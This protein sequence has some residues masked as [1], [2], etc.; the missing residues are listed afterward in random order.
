MLNVC[1]ECYGFGRVP[2]VYDGMVPCSCAKPDGPL[3]DDQAALKTA[4][5]WSKVDAKTTATVSLRN[6][7]EAAFRWRAL[8]DEH[9]DVCVISY[10]LMEH[11]AATFKKALERLGS[12]E[13]FTVPTVLED[14]PIK[15]EL[16]ARIEY[17]RKVLQDND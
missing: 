11:K 8:A 12:M 5:Y 10:S 15:D 3:K 6:L 16:V 2:T 4:D 9:S 1:R 13:A 14:G 7:A 17:A